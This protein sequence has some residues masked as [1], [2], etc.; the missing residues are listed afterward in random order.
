MA[1]RFKIASV[2]LVVLSLVSCKSISGEAK[3]DLAKPVSCTTATQDIAT[4]E[5][6]RASTKKKIATGVGSVVPQLAI[7][8]ILMGDYRNRVKV[9]TGKYNDDIEAKI[10]EIKSECGIE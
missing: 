3:E 7:T 4:L 8:G 10:A 6:E 1:S 2:L 5:G 9:A